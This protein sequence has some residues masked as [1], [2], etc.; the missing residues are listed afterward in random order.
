MRARFH[1]RTEAG[2]VL[3]ARLGHY[4]GLG[5]V[6]LGLDRGGLAVAAE[7]ARGLAAPFDLLP[8][9]TFVLPF[10]A[11]KPLGA[12]GPDHRCAFEAAL[13]DPRAAEAAVVEAL[14]GEADAALAQLDLR[15][16]DRRPLARVEGRTV[17]LVEDQVASTCRVR[18][19]VLYLRPHA[20]GRIIVAAPVVTRAAERELRAVVDAIVA[21]E[22]PTVPC[23]P[24]RIYTRA[25]P[26]DATEVRRILGLARR[27]PGPAGTASDA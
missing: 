21:I 1:D 27:R 19:A 13:H 5:T 24:R 4:A 11:P 22:H 14:R 8:V 20:P 16:R 7:V 18:A 10:A 9:Q 2:A 26:P 25:E 12:V 3:A 15:L 23:R 6:V 17:I